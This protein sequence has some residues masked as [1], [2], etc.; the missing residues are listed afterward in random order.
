MK[1]REITTALMSAWEK[2]G[3]KPEVGGT[4]QY[5]TSRVKKAL[6]LLVEQHLV[7]QSPVYGT[8]ELS[9][10]LPRPTTNP[11]MPD[12][13]LG[14]GSRLVY[15]WSW[16]R[17]YQAARNKGNDRWLIKIGE[18]DGRSPAMRHQDKAAHSDFMHW[19][20][21]LWGH[22][23]KTLEGALHRALALRGRQHDAP[24]RE[25]F[26]TNPHEIVELYQTLM[27]H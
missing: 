25:W 17:E 10:K 27:G 24:G 23:S 19:H 2:A 3:G 14:E 5:W 7:Q 6:S 21:A 9:K 15:A 18:T 16:E 22:D 20:V 26:L 12:L 8:W 4:Q 1:R 11:N 13:S